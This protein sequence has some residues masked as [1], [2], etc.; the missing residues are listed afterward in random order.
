MAPE[1]EPA[2]VSYLPWLPYWAVME[3]DFIQVFRSWVY[4]SWVLVVAFTAIGLFA[5][6]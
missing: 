5:Y 3:A 4:R 6:R 2:Q 1:P